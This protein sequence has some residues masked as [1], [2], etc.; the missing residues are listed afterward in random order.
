MKKNRFTQSYLCILVTIFSLI[1]C[2]AGSKNNNEIILNVGDKIQLLN[3]VYIDNENIFFDG[4]D[5]GVNKDNWYIGNGAWGSGNGGVVPDNVLYSEKGEVILRG[6]GMFYS[7]NQIK[8]V[9][10]LKDGK[11]TGAAL[12][13]KTTFGPGRYE[14]RMKPLPRQGA[15]SAFWTFNNRVVEGQENENHEIDIE[16]PG[17]KESGIISF[18]NILN[19]NY[20][21]ESY[22]QSQD[23]K[24]VID[25]TEICLND[26]NYH[27]FGFDW[28]TNPEKIVYYVDGIITA[29]SD[30]FVPTS[31]TRLWIGNW[32]P[33]NTSFVGGSN[34]ETDYMYIDYIK[35]LPFD[36]TQTYEK[37][38]VNISINL[39]NDNQYPSSPSS[40]NEINKIANGDFE[41]ALNNNLTDYGWIFKKKNSETKDLNEVTY[42][43]KN[44][45]YI[46]Y[47]SAT[48][49][50]GGYLE[51]SIDSVYEGF[52]YKFN[53]Y[54]KSTVSDSK[55][56]INFVPQGS[57][58]YLSTLLVDVAQS[59][60]YQLYTYEF[61]APQGTYS[62][63]INFVNMSN[64]G[65]FHIDD[66]ELIKL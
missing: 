57:S 3:D 18:K 43:D 60:D 20:V 9:G 61:V 17:G 66:V 58:T 50:D 8:G 10:A 46:S 38:D 24:V 34:F 26:G 55:V 29:I 5:N 40:V 13:S 22:Y 64:N 4:F 45:G 7:S 21:T 23:N 25:N 47:C 49:K 11:N 35:Y 2:D 48:I 39:A 54:A 65:E 30:S 28:Y 19:T 33:N 53:F 63:D 27:V 31:S 16:L 37:C 52:K 15:C 44:D 14:T 32:F 41:Y 51:T 59:D 56:R 62:L 42:I 12:I 6:N 1:G 36:E